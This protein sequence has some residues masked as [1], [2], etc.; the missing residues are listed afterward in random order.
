[1]SN[2]SNIYQNKYINYRR[3]LINKCST[4]FKLRISVTNDRKT[5]IN[6]LKLK[7]LPVFNKM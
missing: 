6:L 7:Y 4:Y 3:Q 5:F 2:Y 1:M